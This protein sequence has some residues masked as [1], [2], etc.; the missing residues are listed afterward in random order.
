MGEQISIFDIIESEEELD[1]IGLPDFH[2]LTE[3]QIVNIVA[4]AIGIPF[5]RIDF[6][7]QAHYNNS[8]LDVHLSHYTCDD[9]EGEPFISC[10]FY[11]KKKHYGAGVPCDS[12]EDAI[13]FFKKYK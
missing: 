2:Y 6:G 7:Y 4:D 10:D 9:Q 1:E 5:K 8:V 3:E 12:L 11:N 13:A